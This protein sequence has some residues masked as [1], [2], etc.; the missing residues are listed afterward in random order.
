[1]NKYLIFNHENIAKAPIFLRSDQIFSDFI[2][3]IIFKSFS[4]SEHFDI[5]KCNLDVVF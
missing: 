1:M 4:M 3:I 5:F 2:I